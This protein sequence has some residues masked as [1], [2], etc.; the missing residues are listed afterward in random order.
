MASSLEVTRIS[1]LTRLM[2]MTRKRP[3]RYH[4]NVVGDFFVEKD[5]CT[6]CGV[7]S[8]IAPSLF[9]DDGCQCYVAKQPSSAAEHEQ[10][11]EVLASQDLD[12]VFY[13]GRDET[14]LAKLEEIDEGRHIVF[15]RAG[16]IARLARLLGRG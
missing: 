13:E 15:P 10:M 5:C 6:M 14:V 8:W 16:F 12:C 4:L 1:L 9:A 3:E 11:Y 2:V 7:P